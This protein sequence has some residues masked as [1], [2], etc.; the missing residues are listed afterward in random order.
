MTTGAAYGAGIYLA[1]ES[2]TSFGYAKP[3]KS[4]SH[5]RFANSANVVC[6]AVAEV[7]KGPSV[8]VTPT[9]YYVVK[10]EKYVML[11]FFFFYPAG[12][13]VQLQANSLDFRSY[14]S[15]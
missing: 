1:A 3:G 15:E 6:L 12:T 7:A 14:F 2:G 9:P 11:R 8:P 10:E 5:S 4:W 13:S